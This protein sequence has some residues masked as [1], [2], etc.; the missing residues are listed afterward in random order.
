MGN[1]KPKKKLKDQIEYMVKHREHLYILLSLFVSHPIIDHQSRLDGR[2]SSNPVYGCWMVV[3]RMILYMD[4][5]W[6]MSS[7]IHLH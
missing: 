3:S 2:V 7:L 5:C 1:I 4:V 6:M